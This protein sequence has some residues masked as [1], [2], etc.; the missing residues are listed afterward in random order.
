MKG[1]GGVLSR[2]V[3]QVLVF[4]EKI[5]KSVEHLNFVT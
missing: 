3:V 2:G 4:P 1:K 5:L